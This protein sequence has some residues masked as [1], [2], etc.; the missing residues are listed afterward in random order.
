MRGESVSVR[1]L[2]KRATSC[3]RRALVEGKAAIII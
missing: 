3:S 2:K 1:E